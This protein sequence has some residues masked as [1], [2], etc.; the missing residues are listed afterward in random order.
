MTSSV[1]DGA[2][3]ALKSQRGPGLTRSMSVPHAH[4][5]KSAAPSPPLVDN[6]DTTRVSEAAASPSKDRVRPLDLMVSLKRAEPSIVKTRTGSVLSRGFI[7]KTDYYPSG[8]WL[9]TR[10]PGLVLTRGARQDAPWIWI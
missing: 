4:L 3:G 7:L 6:A 8:L 1:P 2:Q 9:S 10:I 5:D